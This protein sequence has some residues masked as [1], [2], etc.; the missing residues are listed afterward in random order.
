MQ[1]HP[2]AVQKHD[3]N[4]LCDQHSMQ[5]LKV[6]HG[7]NYREKVKQR[8]VGRR[9]F[10]FIIQLNLFEP[11]V[12]CLVFPLSLSHLLLL[13]LLLSLSFLL[14]N[15]SLSRS[16][17]TGGQMLSLLPAEEHLLLL[18]SPET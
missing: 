3:S 4:K 6:H 7:F 5:V 15:P 17:F 10:Y 16:V 12:S 13:I 2:A 11:F 8:V 9:L 1:A 18:L 14:S